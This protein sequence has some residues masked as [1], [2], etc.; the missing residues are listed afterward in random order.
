MIE[1]GKKNSD[2]PWWLIQT[3]PKAEFT[4][5]QHLKNQGFITYCPLFKK[6]YLQSRQLRV[7]TCP[8][9][10]SYVFVEAD[11]TAKRNIHVI[12]STLGVNQLFK[13]GEVPIKISY[14]LILELKQIEEEKLHEMQSH[15]KPG[16]NVKIDRGLYQ[17]FEAVYQMDDGPERAVVL[18]SIIN[19]E[20]PLCI[21]KQSLKKV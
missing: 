13:I 20:T 2:I 6:E 3:K 19:K 1:S 9:F 12:R 21:D 18:L 17:N 5:M 4:A 11:Y 10:P 7:I 15:F 14:K 16:D 8:L